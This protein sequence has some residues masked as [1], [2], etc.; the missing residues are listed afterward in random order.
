MHI[1]DLGYSA[2]DAVCVS[3]MVINA[4]TAT[5]VDGD[6]GRKSKRCTAPGV[7]VGCSFP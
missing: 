3:S 1:F 2:A 4:K 7:Q 6:L 5:R